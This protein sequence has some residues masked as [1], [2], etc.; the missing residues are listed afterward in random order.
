MGKSSP[1]CGRSAWNPNQLRSGVGTTIC[2][3][4]CGVVNSNHKVL[5]G[6]AKKTEGLRPG[7]TQGEGLRPSQDGGLRPGTEGLRPGTGETDYSSGRKWLRNSVISQESATAN[8]RYLVSKMRMQM[9]RY[10]MEDETVLAEL[11][12]FDKWT[13]GRRLAYA[14]NPQ[15]TKLM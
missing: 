13:F 14:R 6:L 11:Q 1:T 12:Q 4:G 3:A 8:D 5:T 2:G 15:D 10:C 9:M 7:E